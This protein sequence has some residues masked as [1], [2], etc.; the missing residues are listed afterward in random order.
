MLR[1]I[2]KTCLGIQKDESVLIVTDYEKL[3]VAS[4]IEK[5]VVDL[6]DEVLSLK[7]KPRS[8]HAEEPPELVAVAMSRADVCII[9]TTKSLSHT[10][11]RKSACEAGSRIASMPG[12]NMEMLTKG[13]MTADYEEV[14]R[15]SNVV[16]T[17]L[18]KANGIR[19]ATPAGTDYTASLDGRTGITDTGIFTKKGAFG[20]LPAG[21]G[22][23]A[24]LEGASNGRI[25]FDGSFATEGILKK[26]I[27]IEVRDGRVKDTDSDELRDY[28]KYKN[29]DNIA[30]IGLGTNPKAKLIGNV[31]EDEK[32]MGTVHV[33]LG[34]NH[35]FG[36]IIQAE[37]HLDGIM[38]MPDVWLDGEQIMSKGRLLI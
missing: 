9:P 10:D 2:L 34:D 16:A 5:A 32:V 23:I 14:R 3:D 13:G 33:A 15:I 8:R 12:I 26:S 21:E 35:T 18:T 38:K 36:G 17:K 20:N 4:E 27:A 6:S 31:L 24:P 37:V 11:A 7:M 29:A 19:I 22:F 25:V 1:D 28:L 30:E